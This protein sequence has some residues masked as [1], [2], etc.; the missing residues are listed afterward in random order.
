MEELH[1]YEPRLRAWAAELD[2]RAGGG[3]G[4][5]R[6][7]G[8]DRGPV[9]GRRSGM[10]ANAPAR[11][12]QS[13]S[14]E[15]SSRRATSSQDATPMPG[16]SSRAAEENGPSPPVRDPRRQLLGG[17]E[18]AFPPAC[19]RQRARCPA[20]AAGRRPAVGLSQ[21][22]EAPSIS[23]RLRRSG[24]S[25]R[26]SVAARSMTALLIPHASRRWSS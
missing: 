21:H 7:N 16:L 14:T 1:E 19:P 12:R 10:S 18:A 11:R 17:G 5:Y 24:I 25:T 9:G 8:G 3:N 23:A 22:S 2:G 20:M 4:L 6:R 13:A 26:T 15:A